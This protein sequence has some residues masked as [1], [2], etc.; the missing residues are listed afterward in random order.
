MPLPRA[1]CCARFWVWLLLCPLR[2]VWRLLPPWEYF[3]EPCDEPEPTDPVKLPCSK[4]KT[5]SRMNVVS[6]CRDGIYKKD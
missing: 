2:N 6:T 5:N 4:N 1:A 3:D